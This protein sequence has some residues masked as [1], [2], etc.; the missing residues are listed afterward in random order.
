MVQPQLRCAAL[1]MNLRTRPTSLGSPC[2]A[3]LSF[4]GSIRSLAF[5]SRR[6]YII[7]GRLHA[8]SSYTSHLMDRNHACIC[9]SLSVYY[10]MPIQYWL[11]EFSIRTLRLARHASDCCSFLPISCCSPPICIPQHG[12]LVSIA[13]P[14]PICIPIDHGHL[15]ILKI[16]CKI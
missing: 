5:T 14:R 3:Q 8:S 12:W 1:P 11:L 15:Y 2:Y 9:I 7:S 4:L 10:P 16:S 13:S 6:S